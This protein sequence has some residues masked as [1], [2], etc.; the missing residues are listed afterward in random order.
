MGDLFR[1][2]V[3]ADR[4]PACRLPAMAIRRDGVAMHVGVARGWR[5]LEG[6]MSGSRHS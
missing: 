3:G 4:G 5:V 6:V 1:A 2:L